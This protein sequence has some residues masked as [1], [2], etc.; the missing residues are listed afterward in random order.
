MYKYLWDNKYNYIKM[1]QGDLE[2]ALE[3]NLPTIAE[4]LFPKWLLDC[5]LVDIPSF[6]SR[7]CVLS[8]YFSYSPTPLLRTLLGSRI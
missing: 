2:E 5:I 1:W 6:V 4:F 3:L 8:P 7:V